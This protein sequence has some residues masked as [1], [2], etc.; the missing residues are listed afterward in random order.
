MAALGALEECERRR[1]GYARNRALLLSALPGLGLPPVTHADGSFYMLLDISRFADSS[2]DFCA[3]ALDA[4]V[5]LTPGADFDDARG[6]KWVRLA[7]PTTTAE[8][9]TGIERLGKFLAT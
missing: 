5:A 3:R 9:E 8:V 1:E 2:A 4:G 7:Y 6:A